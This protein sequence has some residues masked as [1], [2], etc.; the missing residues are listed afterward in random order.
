MQD[1]K[2]GAS[3]ASSAA[4]Y[5]QDGTASKG[6]DLGWFKKGAMVQE[7][8][9]AAFALKKGEITQ[10]LVQT[11]YGY[12]IIKLIDKKITKEKDSAGKEVSVDE[13]RASHILFRSADVNWYL[14]KLAKQVK[15]HLYIKVND[16]FKEILAKKTS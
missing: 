6:G 1:I 12:H 8:E 4:K 10:S 15:I 5:G 13:A 2:S 9:T 11:Q 3:F 16:P 14:D 7:F